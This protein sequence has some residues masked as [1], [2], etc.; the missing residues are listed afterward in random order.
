MSYT[1]QDFRD[2]FMDAVNDCIDSKVSENGLKP[3]V[4]EFLD[5][6]LFHTVADLLSDIKTNFERDQYNKYTKEEC[7][8]RSKAFANRVGY[9]CNTQAK[10]HGVRFYPIKRPRG[11]KV[12]DERWEYVVQDLPV[13]AEECLPMDDIPME[14]IPPAT[15]MPAGTS[16]NSLIA[17]DVRH[18]PEQ[19][20]RAVLRYHDK[21][22]VG[23]AFVKILK[24]MEARDAK[25]T[26]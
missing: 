7:S 2:H 9:C 1:D 8:V 24:E 21:E 3:V 6:G 20:V 26:S 16:V 11:E 4:Q 25:E 13:K 14:D 19:A 15:I 17:D 12:F 10:A 18:S 23:K 22:D 5:N